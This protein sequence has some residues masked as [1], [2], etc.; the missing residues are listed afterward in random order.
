MA[1]TQAKTK[2]RKGNGPFLA[3]PRT[4]T[5]SPQFMQLSGTVT[6]VLLMI[7]TQYT[8]NNNGDFDATFNRAKDWGIGSQQ[9]LSKALQ[10][11]IS[12]GLIIRTREGVFMNPGRK[13]AL[14]A[15]TWQPI[16]EC[17]GKLDVA[18]TTTPPVKFS[19]RNYQNA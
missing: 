7:A 18:A 2:G 9:T 1:A 11:L 15:I 3:L 14:Y 6:K 8:G 17:K 13:C 12:A 19:A 10:Q 16:N 5:S 4:V